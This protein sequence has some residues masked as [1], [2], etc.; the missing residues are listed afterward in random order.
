MKRAAIAAVM[1]VFMAGAAW[2]GPAVYFTGEIGANPDLYRIDLESMKVARLTT[3]SSAEMQPAVTADGKTIAFVSDAAGASSLYLM[4]IESPEAPWKNFAI[5]MGAYA[6]PAFSPDGTQL[7]VSYAPDPEAPLMNTCLAIVDVNARTQ[8]ILLEGKDVQPG[9]EGSDGPILVLDRPQWLDA[10]NLVFAALEYADAESGRLTSATLYRVN[11]SDKTVTRLA[12]GESYF[13]EKGVPRGFKASVPWCAAEGSVIT[14]S[15]IQGHLDRTPMSMAADA[16]NKR[17]LP[18]KDQ[19]YWGPAIQVGG[20]YVYGFR[21]DEG[22]L[23]LA[24]TTNGGKGP[25]RVLPFEG[26]ALDPVVIP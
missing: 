7:A 17:V 2:A 23:R 13:D 18:I 8:K 26:A 22:R 6:H 24:L 19:D 5:G 20:E 12:G 11:L 9:H 3:A 21:D 14:F 4:Q 1:S 16:K 10:T 15:A 25:R